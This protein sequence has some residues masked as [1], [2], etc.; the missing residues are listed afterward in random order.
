MKI[1]A[2]PASIELSKRIAEDI[3][4]PLLIL[5]SKQF[6]DGET[7]LRIN[8]E[9][10]NEEVLII[11]NTFPNQEKSL[12]EIMLIA[13]TLKEYEATKVFLLAP[14]LCYARAD[15]R[16]IEK[17]VISHK[18]T[19]EMLY[20][21]GVDSV[22][23]FNVH[24]K[25]AFTS[26]IPELEKYNISVLSLIKEYLQDLV[27]ESFMIVGPDKGVTDELA[28]FSE[29][30]GISSGHLEKYRDPETHEITMKDLGLDLENKNIILFDDIITS[31]GTAIDACKLILSKKPKSL[32]FIVIHALAKEE[33]FAKFD[34]IGVHKVIST[35]TI[36]RLDIEQI[37]ISSVA[38]KFIQ[39]KF[40]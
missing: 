39:D 26:L 6:T 19:L 38:C 20:K 35:N 8:G 13:S 29:E 37:D 22:L 28:F 24:N 34:E 36:P 33:V 4:L 11:Q 27:D 16:R 14:Y 23:T 3:D 40:L 17:E 30:L 5:E 31:G 15:R 12:L 21:S 10:E 7:Y 32:I 18:I 2:G 9:V 25:E 1:L